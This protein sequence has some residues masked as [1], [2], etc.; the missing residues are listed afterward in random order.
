[1]GG[2]R[3]VTAAITSDRP[4]P[5]GPEESP[6]APQL[7]L[8]IDDCFC[9]IQALLKPGVF[10]TQ[11]RQLD[12]LRTGLGSSRPAFGRRQALDHAGSALLPPAA[13]GRPIKTLPAQNAANPAALACL[14]NLGQ[15]P[16]L[17]LRREPTPLRTRRQLR[18]HRSRSRHHRRPPAFLSPGVGRGLHNLVRQLHETSPWHP[19]L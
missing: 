8:E 19:L 10:A 3:A 9:S 15:D 7:F 12:R 1:M 6:A 4:G 14:I 5:A 11:L 16:Q 2:A 13:Q 17:L 18:V